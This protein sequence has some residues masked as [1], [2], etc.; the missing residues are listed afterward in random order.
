MG[1]L[2]GSSKGL[3]E[4]N[5]QAA[6]QADATAR[7]IERQRIASV[8]AQ[9]D[10]E[11]NFKADLKGENKAT[12]VAGGTAEALGVGDEAVRKR[13]A[14]GGLASTLGVNV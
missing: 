13:R 14:A 7:D 2:F 6:A 5:R 12:V 9:N 1:K 8:K 3:E 11:A 10:M 4:S